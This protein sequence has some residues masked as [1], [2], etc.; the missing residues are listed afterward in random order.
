MFSRSPGASA[1]HFR[2]AQR[3]APAG[4]IVPTRPTILPERNARL[5]VSVSASMPGTPWAFI[6]PQVRGRLTPRVLAAL[7]SQG[8]RVHRVGAAAYL[9]TPDGRH[10]LIMGVWGRRQAPPI[11]APRLGQASAGYLRRRERMAAA[12][13]WRRMARASSGRFTLPLPWYR[14][15][16][17]GAYSWEPEVQDPQAAA[18]ARVEAHNRRVRAARGLVVA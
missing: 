8:W 17:P 18:V 6:A 11:W 5:E 12:Q 10:H 1:H 14:W 13:P 2:Y 15:P 9:H 3:V 7:E 4:R 16:V